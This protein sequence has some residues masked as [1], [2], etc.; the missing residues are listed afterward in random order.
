ME[1]SQKEAK[2]KLKYQSV[3]IE[4]KRAWNMKCTIVPVVSGAI[5][6]LKKGLKK[7]L[8]TTRG[9]QQ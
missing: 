6:I 9:K 4:K 7:H 2:N 3:C 8:E 1:M 5:G